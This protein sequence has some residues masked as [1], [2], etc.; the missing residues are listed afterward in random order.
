AY[1]KAYIYVTHFMQV[2]VMMIERGELKEDVLEH[3]GLQKYNEKLP[4]INSES[5]LLNWGAKLIEGEQKRKQKG[6][7]PIYNPSIALVKVNFENFNEAAIYQSTLKKSSI[8]SFDKVKKLRNSTNDF[9][10]R[11]W[12]E[13][14]EN[15][16]S[17]SPKHSRQLAQEYGVVYVFRR[18]EKK[19]LKSLDLQRDLLFEFVT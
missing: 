6:G 2:I 17:D 19:K 12:N 7:S 18:K 3:F 15:V 11:M 8:R 10:S 9:I 13:I 14:E 5:E 4:R 16:E 1:Q